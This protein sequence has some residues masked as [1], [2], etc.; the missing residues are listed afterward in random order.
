MHIRIGTVSY[1][2]TVVY[3][4]H[5]FAYLGK[6]TYCVFN[7][8]LVQ[9]LFSESGDKLQTYIN[10]YILYIYEKYKRR[11]DILTAGGRI[12]EKRKTLGDGLV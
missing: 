4:I 5:K 7:K 2:H 9:N 3:N 12:K 1:V 11:L 6:E 8:C 10:T